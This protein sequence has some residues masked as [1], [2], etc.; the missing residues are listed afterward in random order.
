MKFNIYI[1]GKQ[2]E[3]TI[4]NITT[5]LNALYQQ[6]QEEMFNSEQY[7][8][9]EEKIAYLKKM[10]EEVKNKIKIQFPSIIFSSYFKES[11]EKLF[12]RHIAK[13]FYLEIAYTKRKFGLFGRK[14]YYIKM[15]Q[16]L[17]Y[18]DISIASAIKSEN[19]READKLTKEFNRLKNLKPNF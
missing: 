3:S 4:E 14:K 8:A 12:L 19:Y 13:G 9:N 1:N 5:A 15:R 6:Q 16:G 11:I 10:L 17:D 2:V 7:I 18:Y